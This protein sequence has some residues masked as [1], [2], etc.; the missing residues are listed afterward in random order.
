MARFDVY[1]L[2]NRDGALVVDVQAN[3]LSELASRVVIP[4]VPIRPGSAESDDRLKPVLQVAGSSYTLL[5]TDIAARPLSRFARTVDNVEA[6]H[7]DD[8]VAAL[9]FLF[10]GF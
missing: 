9:D 10:Q 1:Q 3:L 5:T 6:T 4:L 2:K 7:R 8:I